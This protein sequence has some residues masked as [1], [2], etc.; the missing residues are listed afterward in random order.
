MNNQLPIEADRV[1]AWRHKAILYAWHQGQLSEGQ[2]SK[3][4]SV[5]RLEA[6]KLLEEAIAESG[7]QGANDRPERT[8]DD[9]ITP[10]ILKTVI[11]LAYK[12]ETTVSDFNEALEDDAFLQIWS[13]RAIVKL[14]QIAS[15]FKEQLRWRSVAELPNADI[16]RCLLLNQTKAHRQTFDCHGFGGYSVA[17]GWRYFSQYG[18]GSEYAELLHEN[19]D[20]YWFPLPPSPKEG[21]P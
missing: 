12:W 6:R 17:N 18:D 5:D 21:A 15:S 19:G 11:D 7:W 4:L 16:E 9:Q 20:W 10:A 2:V 13:T 1:E 3:L 14:N 8:E